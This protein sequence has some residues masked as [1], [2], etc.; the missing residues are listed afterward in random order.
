MITD[1]PLWLVVYKPWV[2]FSGLFAKLFFIVTPCID[3]ILITANI[4]NDVKLFLGERKLINES[5]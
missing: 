2:D 5:N 4:P 3:R 1:L